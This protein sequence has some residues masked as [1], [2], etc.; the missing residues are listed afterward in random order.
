MRYQEN[1]QPRN[2]R[3]ES[4]WLESLQVSRV[5]EERSQ[6]QLKDDQ[7]YERR[8]FL[9]CK[10][11]TNCPWVFKKFQFLYLSATDWLDEQR[12]QLTLDQKVW[13]YSY[14]KWKYSEL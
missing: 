7:L 9:D 14:L 3:E 4:L 11:P 10:Q 5:L 2:S 1:E 13:D 8:H 6:S 12:S